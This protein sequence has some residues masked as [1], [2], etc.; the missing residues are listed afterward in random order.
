MFVRAWSIVSVLHFSLHFSG[1]LR[2]PTAKH[3][4]L[5][6]F[7][8]SASKRQ[9]DA[10]CKWGKLMS[11]PGV[12]AIFRNAH[13][14][15]NA[16]DG[17]AEQLE[18]LQK[19]LDLEFPNIV[20]HVA[21]NPLNAGRTMGAV[22]ALDY[23][24]KQGHLEDYDWVVH[25]HPDKFIING[26]YLADALQNHTASVIASF[27]SCPQMIG[28]PFEAHMWDSLSFDLF[29]FRPNSVHRE[30]FSK[31][32]TYADTPERYLFE[33]AFKA[34]LSDGRVMLVPGQGRFPPCPMGGEPDVFGMMHE[35]NLANVDFFINQ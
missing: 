13:V 17:S 24:M 12:P 25:L 11:K 18:E 21:K 6:L 35:H 34:S 23:E 32:E 4:L 28:R 5:F 2:V 14:L 10:L 27:F 8:S 1:G 16:N 9:C 15:V 31:W 20:K 26:G 22:Q 3:P 19:C 30:I 7:T 33:V 29:A